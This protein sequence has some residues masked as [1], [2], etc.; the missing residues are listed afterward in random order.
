MPSP[1]WGTRCPC[2]G[3]WRGRWTDPPRSLTAPRH[4]AAQEQGQGQHR[5][6]QPHPRRPPQ[7]AAGAAL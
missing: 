3:I 4:H 7:V 6:Q 1:I 2:L 5:R